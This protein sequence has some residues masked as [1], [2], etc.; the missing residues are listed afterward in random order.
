MAK[1]IGFTSTKMVTLTS[2][3]FSVLISA[4]TSSQVGWAYSKF[5]ISPPEKRSKVHTTVS[6]RFCG[7]IYNIMLFCSQHGQAFTIIW[8]KENYHGTLELKNM[9][10]VELFWNFC[11]QFF[12][13]TSSFHKSIEILVSISGKSTPILEWIVWMMWRHA[14]SKFRM[15][16]F[17][18]KDE[19]YEKLPMT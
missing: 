13:S 17:R 4:E 5:L 9:M 7:T 14:S 16:P 10:K 1:N 12:S 3:L 15:F 8:P 6:F 19:G 2:I 18:L 11:R